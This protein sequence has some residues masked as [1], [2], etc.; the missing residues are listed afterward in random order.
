MRYDT[1]MPAQTGGSALPILTRD[2]KPIPPPD[3]WK[4]S[5]TL[6]SPDGTLTNTIEGVPVWALR[7]VG[8][9]LTGMDEMLKAAEWAIYHHGEPLQELNRVGVVIL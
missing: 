8:F 2:G 5:I 7:S 6:T 4:L 9:R 1:P 3:R